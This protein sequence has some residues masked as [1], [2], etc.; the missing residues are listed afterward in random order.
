MLRTAFH[1]HAHS[2]P[3]KI[4]STEKQGQRINDDAKLVDDKRL[5]E[6]RNTRREWKLQKRAAT[7]NAYGVANLHRW[8]PGELEWIGTSK[9]GL[10]LYTKY[11]T[12]YTG[13]KSHKAVRT[14]H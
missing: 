7:R 4:N 5:A 1:A 12:C 13:L 11:Q 6:S 3:S 8:L 9:A 10:L 14:S 2:K